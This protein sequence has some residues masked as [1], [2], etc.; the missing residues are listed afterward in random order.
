MRMI[1]CKSLRIHTFCSRA[2]CMMVVFYLLA[3]MAPAQQ[4]NA[5]GSGLDGTVIAIEISGSDVYVGGYFQNAGGVEEA[6][7]VARWDGCQWHAIGSGLNG[8]GT[9]YAIEISGSD[10][11]FGGDFYDAGGN[12]DA[13]IIA[14]W[15]GTSW[16]SL[17][18]NLLPCIFHA[19]V[20]CIAIDGGD[21][22]IGGD[23]ADAGGDP[24]ADFIARWDGSAWYALEGSDT[25]VN[26]LPYD[27]ETDGTDLYV[28]GTYGIK[29]WDGNMWHGL[30]G[31]DLQVVNE[32]E[33]SGNDIYV[34]G[35]FHDA[36]GNPDADGFARWDGN[37]WYSMT[38]LQPLGCNSS[39][40][41][42]IIDGIAINGADVFAGGYCFDAQGVPNTENLGRWDGSNWHAVGAPGFDP[43]GNDLV[44]EAKFG[45]NGLYIGGNFTEVSGIPNTFGIARWGPP[46][47]VPVIPGITNVVCEYSS[48]ISLPTTIEGYTGNWSG[49]GV[50][51]NMFDPSLLCGDIP[52]TF[53]PDTGQCVSPGPS[54][55]TV[56]NLWGTLW[57]SSCDDNGTP[58]D[59]TDDIIVLEINVPGCHVDSTYS[60]SVSSGTITP[61]TGTYG[62][63]SEF[64]LQPGS[65][66]GGNVILTVTD[67]AAPFCSFDFV[68]D[69]P[70][71]CSTPMDCPTAGV[72]TVFTYFSIPAQWINLLTFIGGDPG[73]TW[74]PP[75]SSGTNIYHPC[76]DGEGEFTYS[77]DSAGCPVSSA[78]VTIEW[79]WDPCDWMIEEVC[80]HET[81]EISFTIPAF[82]GPHPDVP[83]SAT[84][85]N[86]LG[87][88]FAEDLDLDSSYMFT[89][90]PELD[91]FWTEC[92]PGCFEVQ[93]W[94]P[95]PLPPELQPIAPGWNLAW[96]YP[97][98]HTCNL[99]SCN[100]SD[101]PSAGDDS[102]IS[103]CPDTIPFDLTTVL[104][105]DPDPG[106]TWS[107]PLASGGNMYDPSLD[108][109]GTFTYTVSAP[110]CPDDV[111]EVTVTVVD[112]SQ[113]TLL[114]TC[115][116]NNT[117]TDTTDDYIVF[118][119]DPIGTYAGT[120]YNVSVSSGSIT[121]GSGIYNQA[122]SFVLQPGSAGS[123]NVI[124]TV[125]DNAAPFCSFDFIIVDPGS[126]S[127]TIPCP[128]GMDTVIY[129]DNIF[130][131]LTTT[132]ADI[133][134]NLY[135]IPANGFWEPPLESNLYDP[136]A[137]DISVYIYEHTEP[138]CQTVQDTV[139]F[140]F[141]WNPCSWVIVDICTS[142]DT[143][144]LTIPS[145]PQG[146]PGATY[147]LELGASSQM[148]YYPDLSID[149]A[150]EYVIPNP[151]GTCVGIYL[152]LN[153]FPNY[154]LG[155]GGFWIGGDL[156]A[157]CQIPL[158]NCQNPP[159][160]GEDSSISL[161]SDTIP[162]DL[163]TVL[164]G[165]P[166]P[167]G[168]WSPPL[169]SGGNM[170]D[171]SLDGSGTFT[172]TVS[173]TDCP[174]A[175]ANV[176][177]TV[178]PLQQIMI[179]GVPTS[180]CEDAPTISL[181]TTQD[182]ITGNWSGPGVNA[183]TFNPDGLSGII[184]IVFMP[185]S[186]QCAQQAHH[187]IT[188]TTP[189]PA[190]INN[191]PANYCASFPPIALAVVQSGIVGNWSGPGVVNNVFDP[192]GLIGTVMLT[193][194]PNT[195]QCATAVQHG[196]QIIDPVI[197]VFPPITDSLCV[198]SLP[199]NLPSSINNITG[200]WS[201]QQVTNNVFDP[202]G[203]QGSID[204][205]FTPT[206]N[207]C[208]VITADSIFVTPAIPIAITDAP[209]LLCALDAAVSL[210]TNQS[211][212]DGT[213][214]GPGVT[215]NT[216][217]PQYLEGDIAIVFSPV[218]SAC[219]LSVTHLIHVDTA[220]DVQILALPDS[221]C[222]MDESIALAVDPATVTGAWLGQGIINN[223]FDPAG[224]EGTILI[225]FDP[226]AG[227][228]AVSAMDSVLVTS[229]GI[230][231]LNIPTTICQS[232]DPVVLVVI[233]N[234]I[235]G[236]W[237]GEGVS[238]NIFDPDQPPGNVI[239]AFTPDP[240]E[241]ALESEI[242]VT[243]I[244]EG[245]VSP[246][247]T[248]DTI[249]KNASAVSL[250]VIQDGI[251]GNWSGPGV[252]N[253]TFDPSAQNGDVV[254]TFTPA[255][256]DC[257]EAG[258]TTIHVEAEA[259]IILT[260]LPSS[261][262]ELVTIVLPDTVD[263]YTGTWSGA[264]VTEDQFDPVD[265]LSI[266]TL[267]FI[268]DSGQCAINA[269]ISINIPDA[270]QPLL[271]LPGSICQ[272]Q[273]SL[274]LAVVQ[275]GISGSWS[276]PG[277]VSDTL[278]TGSL[279]GMVPLAFNPDTGQ[280]ALSANAVID[281]L[282]PPSFI[283]LMADCDTIA[284]TYTVSF[285]IIGGQPTTY[286]V[287]G[288][289][290]ASYFVSLPVS[291]DSMQY[292]YL[293]DDANGCGPVSINGIV[294]CN[295]ATQAGT[296]DFSINPIEVCPGA[297]MVVI[298]HQNESLDPDD[299]LL[300]VLHD[301]P[302]TQLGDIIATSTSLVF[303]YPAGISYGQLYY[304]SAV[305]GNGVGADS[306]NFS[307]PC[308]SVSQGIPVLFFPNTE[309]SIQMK[310]CP[311][312][313]IIVNGV[314]YNQSNPTG[315]EIIPFGNLYG[316]DSTTQVQLS[317]YPPSEFQL[318]QTL[319]TGSS[320]TIN[321]IV[322]DETNPEGNEVIPNGSIHGCDSTIMVSLTFDSVARGAMS[323]VLCK[324]DS[325]VVNDI[326]YN[327]DY[328]NGEQ[329][330][331]GGS[332]YGCDSLLAV[333]LSF[334][335]DADGM[336]TDTINAG[337]SILVNGMVFDE[338]NP[339]GVVVVTGGSVH[340]CDS[341]IMVS[342]YFNSLSLSAEVQS[343]PP[344]CFGDSTGVIVVEALHGPFDSVWIGVNDQSPVLVSLFPYFIDGL[345]AG[346]Y[347]IWIKDIGSLADTFFT[348][349]EFIP[350]PLLSLDAGPDLQIPIGEDVQLEV[351]APFSANS[352]TWSPPDFLSCTD[353]PDP[354]MQHPDQNIQYTIVAEDLN[355]CRAT[356][357]L[358]IHVI[359]NTFFYPTVF[360]PNGDGNNDHWTIY[361]RDPSAVILDLN[362]YDRWGGILFRQSN[363]MANTPDLGWDGTSHGQELNPG[364]YVFISTLALSDG[365][366]IQIKG[367]MTLL[368]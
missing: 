84:G 22:Y 89:L 106:G 63:W 351:I 197:P 264:G 15:D 55:I 268:P 57:N 267:F 235:T 33:I 27:L 198:L 129:I 147:S 220:I 323:F 276:G 50:S 25:V 322:Y 357:V 119:F 28:G 21:V 8:G 97:L 180:I 181:P 256:A 207:Q 87:I 311:G 361:T 104:G 59:D 188:I 359:E 222:D 341:T 204:L 173:A 258:T 80:V 317:F 345:G 139:D 298:H 160:A 229:A 228:C 340:G 70:G 56:V 20:H 196:I 302:G 338:A 190:L 116:G 287:D 67:N 149:T 2:A 110:D 201:G 36:G 355:G 306:I 358:S 125:T 304:V 248:P 167:G 64:Y 169:T 151:Q 14:R 131:Y 232:S 335:P 231:P 319:C 156:F 168:T 308:L 295:C 17:D 154:I 254:L 324:G 158:C 253:N 46:D 301:Q 234:G 152:E 225:Q 65:A 163:T 259:T 124:L 95:F 19:E 103:L 114:I 174:D 257:V 128:D 275:D 135:D 12:P 255:N 277:V 336:L 5:L 200:V 362:V 299:Q 178:N 307:D 37:N 145:W 7:N 292:T 326:I 291:A 202:S 360:S 165:D 239:L 216:F 297:D 191:A 74:D 344:L 217:D 164:G 153:E 205:L 91:P 9:V 48:P 51:N 293:L 262:C 157:I 195:G 133:L 240:S 30:G 90:D 316:C 92:S 247:I 75:L 348:Q 251:A 305:A 329:Y 278:Y 136:C 4:W 246:T 250:P 170:Y 61:S 123:G 285:D 140:D 166:D 366:I 79:L 23:F 211:G 312:D 347:S 43:A 118:E 199:V 294:N 76:E 274:P 69:D 16:N 1:V 54:E 38:G 98:E 18:A 333:H 241:C 184:T 193:F 102:T 331:E 138:G 42:P 309:D 363:I 144:F 271:Q 313:S 96:I 314:T 219:A 332:I 172:Y 279:A 66:G 130:T 209:T 175:M 162:F 185:N 273:A 290:A 117:P 354:V 24:D 85:C 346:L 72:D 107:P 224:L 176:V 126:C 78:V 260:Q 99:P 272:S 60:L 203:L 71:T 81:G 353:C 186:G 11:Y 29:R 334:Y 109:S 13:D 3:L 82:P 111:A 121:P 236:T 283:N 120:A 132:D 142:N 212:V 49:E 269:S 288:L 93:I 105:G 214:S 47:N 88:S 41:T 171:P 244:S 86:G 101:P 215:N 282:Q 300:F 368:K 68:I 141:Q 208:A 339:S 320:I 230:I 289:P 52:I 58:A 249:C 352:W 159:Y 325:V 122:T 330:F 39:P 150:Y 100:C 238:N 10:V 263:G 252:T 137:N 155:L 218:I 94:F 35:L 266:T 192:A 183:N 77:V 148:S 237:S 226:D 242:I 143:I 177:V 206:A 284:Q 210:S 45:S 53:T 213:W 187:N 40:P 315:T 34:G 26:Y 261:L 182:G 245:T 286:M 343:Q 6:D 233:Q 328:P 223:V 318:A 62:G 189:V 367:D 281:I 127:N 115:H 113:S 161:C 327:G 321:G 221:L 280:C 227:Q 364:V 194:T 179:T 83:Y 32:I 108:G 270:V 337:D 73:G 146:P 356:D 310:L 349:I 243:I 303:G 31:S 265:T 365:R 296:M 44:R 342:L 112:L 350:T 134:L